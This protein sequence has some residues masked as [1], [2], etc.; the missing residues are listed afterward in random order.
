LRLRADRDVLRAMTDAPPKL[1]IRG[2]RKSFGDKRVLDGIDLDV[3]PRTSMVVIGGSGSGKSVLLKCVLGLIQPDAGVIEIDGWDV[4]RMRR[5]EAEAARARVGMLF[6]NGALFDSLPVWENVA[7]G[8][9]AQHAA[10]RA[11]ARARAVDIL[12]QV[13]LPPEVA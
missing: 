8:L 6:Q 5:A 7:F 11:E 10:R 2:L 12:G 4:L 13:G 1:R 9:L 3:M